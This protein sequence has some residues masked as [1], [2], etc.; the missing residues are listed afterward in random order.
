MNLA[1]ATAKPILRPARCETCKHATVRPGGSGKEC[2]AE[3]PTVAILP[4]PGGQ[5]LTMAAFPP[6]RDDHWCGRWAARL[7]T[8]S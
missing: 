1:L 3:P 2:R 5:P 4:G 8:M 7:E 6:V